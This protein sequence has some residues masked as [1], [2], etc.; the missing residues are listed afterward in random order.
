MPHLKI[1]RQ[2]VDNQ[3]FTELKEEARSCYEE[4]G[5]ILSLPLLALALAQLGERPRAIELYEQAAEKIEEL[6]TDARVDLAGAACVLLLI[7][8]AI[9]LLEPVM[10]KQPDHSLALARLAWCRL[11]QNRLV[12]ARELYCRSTDLNDRRLPV[13]I[14]L[15]R[16]YLQEEQVETAQQALHRAIEC[17]EQRRNEMPQLVADLFTAQLRGLQL[18]IWVADEQFA[19]AEEWLAERRRDL[20]EDIWVALVTGYSSLLAGNDLHAQAEEVLREGLKYYPHNI[21]ILQQLA[22][23]AQAQGHFMQAVRALR[24]AIY[25]DRD[26]PALWSRLANACLQRFDK[27]A[28]SAAE[29]AVELAEGLTE[30]EDS[31]LMKI[32]GLNAH[33]KNALAQVES[34]E[35]NFT[36]AEGLFREI[37]EESPYFVPSLQGLAQQYMQQGQLDDALELY[38]QIKQIDPVK[39][40]SA[41]INARQYPEDIK[42]LEHMEKTAEIP[43]IEGQVRSGI[44]FQLAAAW[45]KRGDHEKAFDLAGK[46]NEASRRFLQYDAR[47]HRNSCARIRYAFCKELYKNRRD[48][49]SDSTLPVYVLGMPRSG[50]TLVEQIIAGHSRIFGAGEL[51]VIPQRIAGLNRWERHV[52]SGRHYPDCIDDLTPYITKG[53]ARGIIEDLKDLA[54]KDKPEAAHVVDKL[55]HNF[56]N[57]GFIKFLF[58]RAKIISVR[59]DPRDIAISNYFTD[60][61]AKHGGMGFAYNLTDIGEQLADHNLLMHHWNR[62][63]PGEILEINYEDVVDDL[64]GSAHKLL[65]YIGVDWEPQVLSLN[66]LERPIKT[67]SVWQVR[68]PIYKTSKARWEPY[69]DKL[70]DL[71]KGTNAKITWDPIDDMLTLPAP[72]FLQNGVALYQKGDLNGAELSFKKML[73]HNPEHAAC[74]YMVGMVYFSKG[75]LEE[76]IDFVEKS[77]KKCPWQREWRENLA[78]AYRQTGQKEKA[79]ELLKDRVG[80]VDQEEGEPF[81]NGITDWGNE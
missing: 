39:A 22:E 40:H 6:D 77:L 57:I 80:R 74:N 30:S 33:A 2:L 52:G 67:A 9:Q 43:S 28:R 23:L 12:E 47:N 41:L 71:I 81:T 16:L 7:D 3:Q 35:Q 11:Q 38:E 62:I 20:A 51:G 78:K 32:R 50:T 76:G 19:R 63:F 13:W 27:Q 58:P 1:L 36:L 10:Q 14:A 72:G 5:D 4:M 61:Q 56:E 46:A 24:R 55:P 42:I 70:G 64:E 31:P 37:L 15:A 21:A 69:R 8:D 48:Y 49:G 65:E 44:M 45:E 25:F 59:R 26:N 34:Q 17:F 73:H 68:Q 66:E 53:I 54:E 75:H 29:K 79:D 60:Y 18:E